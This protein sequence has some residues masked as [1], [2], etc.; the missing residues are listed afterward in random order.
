MNDYKILFSANA[1]ADLDQIELYYKNINPKIAAKFIA[2]LQNQ[3]FSINTFPFG[4]PVK[5]KEVRAKLI[6]GF[7]YVILYDFD[8]QQKIIYIN[9]IYHSRQK[10]IE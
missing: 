10:T 1:E 3:L 5:Y 2:S 4:F 6:K 8:E 7:P 9:R